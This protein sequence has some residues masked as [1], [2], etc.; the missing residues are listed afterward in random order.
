MTCLKHFVAAVLLWLPVASLAQSAGDGGR[1]DAFR[2]ADSVFA[3]AGFVFETLQP[4]IPAD[5]QPILIRM[6]NAI[7]AH[8]EWFIEY[9]NKYAA[10]GGTLPYD[11]HFGISREEYR[12]VQHLESQPPQMVVVDSQKVAVS[13]DGGMLQ[14]RSEGSTRLLDYLFIDVPHQVVMYGGDTIPF[15]GRVDAG[16]ASP[17][18]KWRGYSWRLE[19]TD[20]GATLT[21]GKVTARV[22]EVD[23]GLP[24]SSGK[25]SLQQPSGKIGRGEPPGKAYIRIEYQDMKAGVTTASMELIGYIR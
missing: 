20:V 24:Q 2:F 14:F 16:A 13:K 5:L 1:D 11:E 9:R 6:N 7:V 17:Y 23:L 15:K 10:A 18:G 25:M 19:R 22:I 8:K 4:E 3:R 21:A 12:K